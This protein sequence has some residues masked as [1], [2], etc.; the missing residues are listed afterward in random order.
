M[1]APVYEPFT[2]EVVGYA[3]LGVRLGEL[4]AAGPNLLHQSDTWC[5]LNHVQLS[6]LANS[7]VFIEQELFIVR[8]IVVIW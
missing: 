3:A 4:C 7:H 8:I 5:Y 2:Q 6:K 1:E